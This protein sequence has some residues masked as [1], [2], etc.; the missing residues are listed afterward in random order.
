MKKSI[1][2]IGT[3][4]FLSFG[5]EAEAARVKGYIKTSS[6]KYVQ[7]H[8]RTKPDKNYFNNYSSKGNTSPNT[9]KNGTVSFEQYQQKKHKQ[10]YNVGE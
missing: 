6:G 3:F 5:A 7:T 10:Q 1:L 8:L 2:I 9:G 4:A